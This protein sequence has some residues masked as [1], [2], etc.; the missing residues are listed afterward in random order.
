MHPKI[1]QQKIQNSQIS[2]FP[3]ISDRD[4]G[5]GGGGGGDGGGGGGCGGGG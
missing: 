2:L 3:S 1:Q 5:G 4:A